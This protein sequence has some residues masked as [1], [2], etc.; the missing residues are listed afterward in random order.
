MARTLPAPSE[1]GT[2]G[3]GTAGAESAV[4]ADADRRR[5]V[6]R[7]R[8]RF[9]RDLHDLLGPR[10]LA[11][12]LQCELALRLMDRTPDSARSRLAEA[13]S[14]MREIQ[15]EARRVA[16]GY[17]CLSLDSEIESVRDLLESAGVRTEAEPVAAP[18]PAPLQTVLAT[19][20]R[21]AAANV[22]RHSRALNCR[23]EVGTPPGEVLLTVTNDGVVT[24][25]R[26]VPPAPAGTVGGPPA[27]V[28]GQG[29]GLRSLA[30][31]I[32]AAG[33]RLTH[34]P[35]PAG[36]YTLEARFPIVAPSPDGSR[37]A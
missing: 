18:L 13:L 3:A 8:L 32:A 22:L 33:G 31:R 23:V 29:L 36:H 11:I 25:G 28:P 9:A 16:H 14:G 37:A 34:G 7:E 30:E 27:P 15:E 4:M 21:E 19:T 6:V 10:L 20:L 1:Q 2:A 26:P 5:V 17:H 12:T 35:Y 24:Q